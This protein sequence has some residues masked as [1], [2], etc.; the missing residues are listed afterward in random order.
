V[1]SPNDQAKERKSVS[2]SKPLGIFVISLAL[3][4]E[5]LAQQPCVKPQHGG[6]AGRLRDLCEVGIA[7]AVITAK[8]GKVKRKFKSDK[9]GIFEVCL[10]AGTYQI[11]VEKYGFKRYILNDVEVKPNE[12]AKINLD[13]EAGY[14]TNDPNAYEASLKPCPPPNKGM[15]RTRN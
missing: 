8:S 7:K 1:A 4:I 9:A 15:Q 12:T 6:V 14:A 5:V 10:P 11:I 3:F 2:I 13:L